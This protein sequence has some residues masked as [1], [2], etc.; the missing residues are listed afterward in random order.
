MDRLLS[1][2]T[3]T[4]GLIRK[5]LIHVVRNRFAGFDDQYSVEILPWEMTSCHQ[6]THKEAGE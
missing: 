6:E 1:C 5:L 2:S 4:I 3:V